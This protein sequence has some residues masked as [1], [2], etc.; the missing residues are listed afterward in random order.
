MTGA[1]LPSKLTD[2]IGSI[3]RIALLS[4][5]ATASTPN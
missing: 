3:A 2:F 1:T 5:T 4:P